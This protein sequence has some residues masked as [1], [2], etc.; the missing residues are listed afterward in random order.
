MKVIIRLS[1][2]TRNNDASVGRP[3]VLLKSVSFYSTV[4]MLQ[5]LIWHFLH[6]LKLLI[7]WKNSTVK[8]FVTLLEGNYSVYNKRFL[9][10]KVLDWNNCSCTS[11]Q[12]PGQEH[13]AECRAQWCL[14]KSRSSQMWCTEELTHGTDNRC[15]TW[16]TWNMT[17]LYCLVSLITLVWTGFP[18]KIMQAYRQK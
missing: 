8:M 2:L 9:N 11:T 16:H 10:V 18:C 14:M 1:Y 4:K 17:W 12:S 13:E 3:S 5:C 6:I 15:H 7:L